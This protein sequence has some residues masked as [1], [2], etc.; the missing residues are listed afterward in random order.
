VELREVLVALR[1]SWWLPLVGLVVGA[2][3]GLVLSLLQTPQYTSQTQLFVSVSGTESTSE[4]FQGSQFSQER[5]SS[6]ARLVA[7]EELAGRVIDRLGLEESPAIVSDQVAAA[8]VTDTVLIDVTVTDPSA[9]RAQLIAQVV[10]DEFTSFPQ[11]RSRRSGRPPH[12]GGF[13]SPESSS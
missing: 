4:A 12:R 5:V 9:E 10:G 1:V 6:Y 7:G 3:S 2:A 13:G 11:R 8:V